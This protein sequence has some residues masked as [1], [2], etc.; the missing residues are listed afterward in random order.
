[1]TAGSDAMDSVAL[2]RS[3][4]QIVSTLTPTPE[5]AVFDKI[6]ATNRVPN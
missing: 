6:N 5:E 2:K 4:F 3:G 1:M